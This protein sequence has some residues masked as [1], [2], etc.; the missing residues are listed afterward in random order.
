MRSLRRCVL[1]PLGLLLA[2]CGTTNYTADFAKNDLFYV[3]VPFTTKSPGDRPVHVLPVSDRR[4]AAAMPAHERGFPITYA[5]DDFWERPV[6]EMLGEVLH[7]QLQDSRLFPMVCDGVQADALLV[8]PTLVA[9]TTAAIEGVSGSRSFA[10]VGLKLQVFGPVNAN[11]KRGLLHERVYA[12]RQATPQELH[13]T[14]PYRLVGRALQQAIAKALLDLD[15]S[16]VARSNVP[17][18][19]AVET[20]IAVEAAAD[21]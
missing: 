15:G 19:R 13:P 4:D 7:R 20:E 2:A 17:S 9:F 3:D 12:N 21:R 14:S 8:K 6:A 11:G 18:E 10:E 5:G 1:F 16:N